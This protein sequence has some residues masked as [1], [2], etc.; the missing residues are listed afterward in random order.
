MPTL[1]TIEKVLETSFPDADIVVTWRGPGRVKVTIGGVYS[2]TVLL[3]KSSDRYM[4]DYQRWAA[5]CALNC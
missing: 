3:A 5:R 2:R 4:S 1:Q